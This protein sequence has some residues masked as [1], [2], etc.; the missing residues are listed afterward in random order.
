MAATATREYFVMVLWSNDVLF[1]D[2]EARVRLSFLRQP[3][4]EMSRR[5]LFHHLPE[6]SLGTCRLD[7]RHVTT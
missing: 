1:F 5:N 7:Y 3:K 6:H 4:K 2:F